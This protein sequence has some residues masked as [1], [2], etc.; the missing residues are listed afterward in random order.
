MKKTYLSPNTTVVK[1]ELQNMIAVSTK[2]LDPSKE[3]I[4]TQNGNA[5]TPGMSRQSLWDDEEE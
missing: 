1:V 4:E 2:G 3:T 5:E